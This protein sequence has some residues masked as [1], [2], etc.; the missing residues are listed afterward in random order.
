MGLSWND[1]FVARFFL[2]NKKRLFLVEFGLILA[3]LR[4]ELVQNLV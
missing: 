4:Q 2:N 3:D 1:V